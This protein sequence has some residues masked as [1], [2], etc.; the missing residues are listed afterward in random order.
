MCK[1]AFERGFDCGALNSKQ[2]VG[3]HFRKTEEELREGRMESANRILNLPEKQRGKILRKY[4]D[5]GRDFGQWL[6]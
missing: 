6:R 5:S 1:C 2:C 3:C 4:H